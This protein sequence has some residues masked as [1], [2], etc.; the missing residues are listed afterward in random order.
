MYEDTIEAGSEDNVT[1]AIK[2]L[3]E[4]HEQGKKSLVLEFRAIV[5]RIEQPPVTPANSQRFNSRTATGSRRGGL[6]AT[7]QQLRD[8][9]ASQRDGAADNND[10]GNG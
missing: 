2:V 9:P 7:Q 1:G 5:E 4:Y 10:S 3:K 8:L 6:T